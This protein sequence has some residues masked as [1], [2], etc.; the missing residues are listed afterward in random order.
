MDANSTQH[1]EE[2]ASSQ[3]RLIELSTQSGHGA[4]EAELFERVP[5]V[6]AFAH[7]PLFRTT[8]TTGT[9]ASRAS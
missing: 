1:G 4:S 3:L 8:R 5:L 6:Q 7:I 2:A 9:R